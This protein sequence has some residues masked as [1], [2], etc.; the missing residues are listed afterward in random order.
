MS[1]SQTTRGR[2]DP[3]A[4]SSIDESFAEARSY[5]DTKDKL[6]STYKALG[7]KKDALEKSTIEKQENGEIAEANALSSD[8]EQVERQIKQVEEMARQYEKSLVD[9]KGETGDTQD[10]HFDSI[11]RTNLSWLTSPDT[12]FQRM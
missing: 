3:V 11:A 6:A 12:L 2:I 1:Q 5:P 8:S 4:E 10:D 7:I 9:G